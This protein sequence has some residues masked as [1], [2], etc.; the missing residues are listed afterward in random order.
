MHGKSF[1][2]GERSRSSLSYSAVA[3][4]IVVEGSMKVLRR[5]GSE[6]ST[7]SRKVLLTRMT[8][9]ML[10][11]GRLQRMFPRSSGTAKT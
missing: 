1:E 6:V 4:S 5:S 8:P 2:C 11:K 10:I 9:T 3:K 7:R